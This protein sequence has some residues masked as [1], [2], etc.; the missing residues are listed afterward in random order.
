MVADYKNKKEI[1]SNSEPV[2]KYGKVKTRA[3]YG[4]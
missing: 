1:E 4:W 2:S 3:K